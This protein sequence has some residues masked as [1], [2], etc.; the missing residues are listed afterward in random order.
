MNISFLA[1][2]YHKYESEGKG[3]KTIKAQELW[4]AILEAQI[5]TGNPYMLYKDHCNN[6]SNQKNLGTIQCSNLCTE[7][8]Q[9]TSAEETAVCNLASINLQRFVVDGQFDFQR[10]YEITYIVTKN[11]NKVIDVN[12][13]PVKQAETSNRK[14]RPIG[15][16]V[17][18]LADAF[19]RMRCGGGLF[20][21]VLY[22]VL[23]FLL[24]FF[25]SRPCLDEFR[26]R[27][28]P[29]RVQG[30]RAAQH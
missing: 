10:L 29:V 25:S 4:F 20:G 18:G 24:I 7:I 14:H 3:R 23:S 16:G 11:L 2:R 26:N 22:F 21:L 19:I 9:Y 12:Y 15:L 30:G 17:Q 6:K 8:I 1:P 5:E 28:L 27:Q 13:Y